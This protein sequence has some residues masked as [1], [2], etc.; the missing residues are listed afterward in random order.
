VY[1]QAATH[2]DPIPV[3]DD[4]E[5]TLPISKLFKVAKRPKLVE[6]YQPCTEFTDPNEPQINDFIEPN[7]LV[8][9]QAQ[10]L[11]P[12]E[13]G[14]CNDEILKDIHQTGKEETTA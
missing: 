7:E 12:A 2:K 11:T 13:E 8:E 14:G 5:D 9:P 1:P 10:L 3:D 4:G 6:Q